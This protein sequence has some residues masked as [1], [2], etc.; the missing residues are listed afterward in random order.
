MLCVLSRQPWKYKYKRYAITH[1]YPVNY[2]PV[3]K[4]KL[5]NTMMSIH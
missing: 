5:S 2:F 3:I 4:G 1:C